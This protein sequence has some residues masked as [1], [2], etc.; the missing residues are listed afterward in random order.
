MFIHLDLNHAVKIVVRVGIHAAPRLS[1]VTHDGSALWRRIPQVARVKP[2]RV[3]VRRPG[4]MP[5]LVG[6]DRYVPVERIRFRR[7]RK[8][9]YGV[10]ND[11]I[12]K[13]TTKLAKKRL[14]TERII[15]SS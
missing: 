4:A 9:P 10:S 8:K 2:D 12:P 1:A 6:T 13:S 7:V 5:K 15:P 3:G 14:P 11:T